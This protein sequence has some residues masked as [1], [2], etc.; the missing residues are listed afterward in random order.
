MIISPRRITSCLD[1][2]FHFTIMIIHKQRLKA[3]DTVSKWLEISQPHE[4]L[5]AA[6]SLLIV[7]IVAKII[8]S[9]AIFTVA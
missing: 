4:Y 1:F 6:S 8:R 9:E 5:R 7:V 3:V 2:Y